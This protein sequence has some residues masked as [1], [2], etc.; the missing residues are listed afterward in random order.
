M[1]QGAKNPRLHAVTVLAALVL[2]AC[3]GGGGDDGP[4]AVAPPPPA[5]APGPSAPP[6]APAPT[7]A[8]PAPAPAPAAISITSDT[9]AQPNLRYQ[10]EAPAGARV[11]IT[12]PDSPT[13]AV[14]DTVTVTGMTDAAWEIRQNA[15]QLVATENLPGNTAPGQA[16]TTPAAIGERS[17]WSVASNASG[18][19]LVGVENHPFVTTSSGVHVSRDG[20]A[21]WVDAGVA[22]L[23]GSPIWIG[24]AMNASGQRIVAVEYD[25]YV[26]QSDDAGAQWTRVAA[27]PRG[28]WEGAAVSRQ[29]DTIAVVGLNQMIRVSTD[30]GQTWPST[31]MAAAWRSIAISTDA[32]QLLAADHSGSVHIGRRSDSGWI[33]SVAPIPATLSNWYRVA[34]SADGQVLVAAQGFNP[35]GGANEIW[36]SRD[37]GASWTPAVNAAGQR[38][39]GSWTG[40]AVSGDG[41]RIAATATGGQV[42]MAEGGTDTFTALPAPGTDDN[43]RSVALS[44]DGNRLVAVT[45][46]AVGAAPV[47]GRLHLSAGNRTS[48]GTLGS[49]AADA[50]D[51]VQLEYLGAG[52]FQVRE[53]SGGPFTIR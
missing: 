52:R 48:I 21:T 44:A 51:M 2:A 28:F 36:I 31:H 18:D 5:P 29:G 17:W 24:V 49:I 20:G 22:G 13:L 40:V 25:G 26:H 10:V 32:Q 14:G 1:S 15:G 33:W 3:G 12:L 46:G 27:L 47:P 16:W 6:P 50:G 45:G 34:S 4:V 9:Q 37:R 11:A 39:N 53:A 38:L 7:P 8:P 42:V 35:G 41:Q 43:W 23:A 30:G 19:V